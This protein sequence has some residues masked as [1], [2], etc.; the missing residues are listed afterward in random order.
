VKEQEHLSSEELDRLVSPQAGASGDESLPGL[1]ERARMHLKVCQA[2]RELLSVHEGAEDELRSLGEGKRAERGPDCPERSELMELAAGT[3]A[4]KR[5]ELMDHIISCD[6]CGPVFRQAV[7]HFS[8]ETSAEEHIALS[9]LKTTQ[10]AYQQQLSKRLASGSAATSA[11]TRGQIDKSKLPFPLL[12]SW[13]YPIAAA[14]LIVAVV[15]IAVFRSAGPEVDDLLAQAYTEQRTIEL[16]V[17]GAGPA[18]IRQERGTTDSP[19]SKPASLLEAEVLT[20][21]KL[22]KLPNSATWMATRGR[23]EI[24]EWQ[25]TQA[26]RSFGQALELGPDSADVRRDLA[27]AYFEKASV[28]HQ[29]ADYATAVEQLGRALVLRPG[30]PLC[31]F[32]RAIV[33][34][35]MSLYKNSLDDWQAYLTVDP[36]G[37]WSVEARGRAASV[38]EKIDKQTQ[39]RNNV[40]EDPEQAEPILVQ[41]LLSQDSTSI[42]EQYIAVATSKWLREFGT[43]SQM[44]ASAKGSPRTAALSVLAQLFGQRHHDRWLEDFLRS[45]QGPGSARA[46]AALAAALDY[47]ARGNPG[48]ARQQ[49]EHA[50]R[51]FMDLGNRA[52]ATRARLEMIYALQRSLDSR[53]CVQEARILD[54]QLQD[55]HYVWIKTDLLLEEAACYGSLQ[56]FTPAQEAV[57]R[58]IVLARENVFPVLELRGLSFASDL[59]ERSGNRRLGWVEAQQ[60]LE[61]LRIRDYPPLRAYSLYASIGSMAEDFREWAVA[62][63]C[64]KES[65]PYIART[66]N[67]STEGL[68]RY[69]LAIDELALGEKR[70]AAEELRHV[71]AIFDDIPNDFVAGNYRLA[72]EVSLAA[73]ETSLGNRFDAEKRLSAVSPLIAQ[74]SQ[75]P[76]LEEF[77]RTS[78]ELQIARGDRAGAQN[79]L[80]NALAV[81]QQGLT[82]LNNDADRIRWAEQTSGTYRALVELLVQ[83]PS[84]QQEALRIWEWYRS[85]PP[86]RNSGERRATGTENA[87]RF[88]LDKA[89][90]E[91]ELGL[92]GPGLTTVTFLTY[93]ELKDGLAIW[94]YDDR[95]VEFKLVPLV[96]NQLEQTSRRFGRLCSDPREDISLLGKEGRQLYDWLIAPV[97]SLLSPSRILWI[98][99]DGALSDLPFGALLDPDGKFLAQ[100]YAIG[101]RLGAPQ[102]THATE[103]IITAADRI[104]ISNSASLFENRAEGSTPLPEAEREVALVAS[105]F[106]HST[107]ILNQPVDL[108]SFR[109]EILNSAIFHYAGHYTPRDGESLA[110]DLGRSQSNLYRRNTKTD[111]AD[112]SRC[113]LVVLSACSTAVSTGDFGPFDPSAMVQPFLEK[114]AKRVVATRWKVDS[115]Q[116]AQLMDGFYSALLAGNCPVRALQQASKALFQNAQFRHPYYWAGFSVFGKP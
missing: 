87:L 76:I 10:P 80:R 86:Q 78:A 97:R 54:S 33:Y 77:Y 67:R 51:L 15:A 81:S 108:R 62:A 65:L 5:E 88:S 89:V 114:G 34:E 8:S 22:T 74:V 6:H 96:T 41:A 36:N 116:T 40:F 66:P 55:L 32:N 64:W 7:T 42:D 63:A 75:S 23:I 100:E 99:P 35:R 20:K 4:E 105:R 2:C 60:A 91:A 90:K 43:N 83:N 92:N 112:F 68:A 72:S 79:N 101:L 12:T 11:K 16:R 39:S 30:D 14:L 28:E 69:R 3:T 13:L 19:L 18:P 27:T 71:S 1:V 106:R 61:L 115:G 111:S 98:E 44:R 107:V 24:L 46:A 21:N 58:A 102:E 25:Y 103:P 113:K 48:S 37:P 26:I 73:V 57:K 53:R 84:Q 85:A 49:A 31:L 47:S 109:N 94:V 9:A 29:A 82:T 52:G 38:K 50:V 70:E 110:I 45:G 17:S 104:F 95:G 56:D 93:V 59:A